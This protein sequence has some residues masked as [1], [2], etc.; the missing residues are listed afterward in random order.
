MV[1]QA[2]PI[3]SEKG[4]V[5]EQEVAPFRLEAAGAVLAGRKASEPFKAG[6]DSWMSDL[7]DLELFLRNN[8]TIAGAKAAK[9]LFIR[10]TRDRLEVRKS[11]DALVAGLNNVDATITPAKLERK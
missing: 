11:M 2:V 1:M 8:R 5:P 6:F 7:E 3:A 4:L 9:S 10:T